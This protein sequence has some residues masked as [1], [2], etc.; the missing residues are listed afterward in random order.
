L[1]EIMAQSPVNTEEAMAR[2]QAVLAAENESKALQFRAGI[3]MRNALNPEQLRKLQSLVAKE[4]PARL[5]GG[6]ATL[7]DRIQQL[8]SELQKRHAGEPPVD[9]LAKLKAIEQIAREGRSG[10]AKTQLEA[11]LRELRPD[12]PT[13]PKDTAP[14]IES[15]R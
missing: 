15:P 5:T 9:V 4:G 10:E 2:F 8:R 14:A 1:L 7:S 11:L 13:G 12:P 3:A 6:P